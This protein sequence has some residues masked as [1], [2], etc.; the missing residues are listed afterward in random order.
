V[1]NKIIAALTEIPSQHSRNTKIYEVLNQLV[2]AEI[3]ASQLGSVDHG[4]IDLMPFGRIN[5]P[6]HKMGAIDTLDLFGLDELIIFSF[7]YANRARYKKVADIG[8]NLGL[9]S[10]MMA[11]CGWDVSA[12][13]PDPVHAKILKDNLSLNNVKQVNLFEAAVSD[14]AGI[15]EFVRVLGNTTGSHLAG[16]KSN[17]YGE[18]ERFPVNVI[19][20]SNVIAEAD[21]IK[22]DAEGQE[23]IIILGTEKSNWDKTD[24]IVEVGS[25]DNATAIYNHLVKLGVNLFSQKQGW[26]PVLS[27]EGM[28]ISYK[29]GSLFISKKAQMPWC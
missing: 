7:Y 11:K 23:K 4:H 19:S 2:I 5:L 25:L 10:I 3:K 15:L 24:M 27:L 6:Y 26:Q 14:K 18:L 22:L 17:P 28:P 12:F 21:F 13:E 29:E 16:A 9:H 1:I 8:A 20:I